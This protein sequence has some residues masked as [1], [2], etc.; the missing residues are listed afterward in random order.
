MTEQTPDSLE[1]IITDLLNEI[2][3]GAVSLEDLVIHL[4]DDAQRDL[5]KASAAMIL[6]AIA[7]RERPPADWNDPK[8]THVDWNEIHF[9][10]EETLA[11][12]A[13]TKPDGLRIQAADEFEENMDMVMYFLCAALFTESER[14]LDK[15]NDFSN[16]RYILSPFSLYMEITGHFMLHTHMQRL[17]RFIF[18][19]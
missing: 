6:D 11:G 12:C 5:N 14:K 18:R 2:F 19:L 8:D 7:G 3:K 1:S 9:G 15:T 13:I 17:L 10:C 4:K 16:L